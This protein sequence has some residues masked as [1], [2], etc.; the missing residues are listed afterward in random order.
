MNTEE[1]RQLIQQCVAD[2]DWGQIGDLITR[3]DLMEYLLFY[4]NPTISETGLKIKQLPK[5]DCPLCGSPTKP[6]AFGMTK[7]NVFYLLSAI[8]LS[9]DSIK[10]GDDGYVHHELIHDFCQ[11][12]FKHDKGKKLG[13]GIS[14]TSYSTMTKA[15]WDF[16]AP[17]VDTNDKMQRDGRFKPTE[18]CYMFCRGQIAVP[19]RIEILDAKVCRY[20]RK[21]VYAAKVKD[22]N[23]QQLFQIYKTW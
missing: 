2:G 17:K 18:K 1:K 10:K 9:E 22:I 21:L 12:K 20:S 8:Y 23:L 14:F 4:T 16:L 15:P 7:R 6:Q 19:E 5:V 13:K 11:G 3:N